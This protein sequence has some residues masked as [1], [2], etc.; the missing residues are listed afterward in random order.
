MILNTQGAF[1]IVTLLHSGL[2]NRILV[3]IESL[4]LSNMGTHVRP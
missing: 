3:K 4:I 1:R 2:T